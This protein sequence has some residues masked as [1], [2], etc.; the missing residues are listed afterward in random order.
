MVMENREY[1]LLVVD[2][3]VEDFLYRQRKEDEN[4]PR[5]EIE[6]LVRCGGITA[7]DIV[8]RF[9]TRLEEGLKRE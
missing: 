3:L 5:G 8:H 2:D 7:D 9:R 1:V 4:L 6:R